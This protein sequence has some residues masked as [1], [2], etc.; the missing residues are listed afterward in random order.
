MK[1]EVSIGE[2]VDKLSILELKKEYITDDSKL[3]NVIKE[4]NYL[5]NIV[6]DVLNIN[7]ELYYQ[8]KTIN[9]KLWVIED[10]IRQKEN[11]NEFDSEFI[12]LARSVYVTNDERANLKREINVKYNS[13]L[14]EEKH[15]SDYQIQNNSNFTETTFHNVMIGFKSL[16]NVST[17]YHNTF[18][19]SSV[20]LHVNE[21]SYSTII[22][23]L[24]IN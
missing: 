5:E 4:Y 20:G 16:N 23:T 14:I 2:I 15:Y 17:G 8:L 3:K 6:F 12:E 24:P 18:I 21:P 13:H 19:G 10:K 11:S 22:T 1:I 9:H 7:K